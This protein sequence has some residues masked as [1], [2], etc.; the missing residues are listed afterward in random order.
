VVGVCGGIGAAA[1]VKGKLDPLADVAFDVLVLLVLPL[2]GCG[3]EGSSRDG[4]E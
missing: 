1:A 4:F 2:V 3:T